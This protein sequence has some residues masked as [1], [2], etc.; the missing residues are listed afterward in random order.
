MGIF[1]I[2]I[3]PSLYLYELAT[4]PGEIT[5]L[6]NALFQMNR[7]LPEKLERKR[8]STL[9]KMNL[10]FVHAAIASA[11]AMPVILVH[12]LHW[13]NPCRASIAGHRL[14]RRCHTDRSRIRW[15]FE[16]FHFVMELF[17]MMVNHWLWSLSFHSGLFAIC[18]ILTM[19]VLAIQQFIQRYLTFTTTHCTHKA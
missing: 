17:V 9:I 19:A 13:G 8:T 1:G 10:V 5:F 12:G 4:K 2:C 11:V 3:R 14:I 15:M 16:A 7:I 18:T 6:L